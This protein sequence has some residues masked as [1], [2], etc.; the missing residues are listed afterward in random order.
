MGFVSDL[1]EYVKQAI[2]SRTQL[3]ELWLRE[4]VRAVHL[5]NVHR[6]FN[7]ILA[8]MSPEEVEGEQTWFAKYRGQRIA[9]MTLPKESLK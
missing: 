3:K 6:P 1:E 9:K 8:D 2:Y 7:D 5:A 4:C